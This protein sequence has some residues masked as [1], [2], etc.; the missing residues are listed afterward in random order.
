MIEKEWTERKRCLTVRGLVVNKRY[1][2]AG[3]SLFG[4]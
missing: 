3:C 2:G 1:I 4:V